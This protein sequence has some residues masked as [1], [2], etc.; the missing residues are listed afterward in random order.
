MNFSNDDKINLKQKRLAKDPRLLIKE[1]RS[2]D[3]SRE[4]WVAISR[5][6]R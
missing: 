2:Y 5:R 1:E 6:I 3:G 4:I